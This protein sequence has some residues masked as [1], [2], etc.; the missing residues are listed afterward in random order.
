MKQN[1]WPSP[2]TGR[3]NISQFSQNGI[4]SVRLNLFSVKLLSVAR[5]M[6]N[7]VCSSYSLLVDLLT[8]LI[9][10]LSYFRPIVRHVNKV[11]GEVALCDNLPCYFV[12]PYQLSYSSP[13]W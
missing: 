7:F 3:N 8:R 11:G 6:D 2:Y 5:H 10:L 13:S 9:S 4:S 12:S 1:E